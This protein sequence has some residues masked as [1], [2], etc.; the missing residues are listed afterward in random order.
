MSYER[1]SI[2]RLEAYVPGEQPADIDGVIK[3]NTNEN[4][5]PPA[6]AVMQT[7]QDLPPEALRRYPPPDAGSFRAAAAA[8]HGVRCNQV[9]ATNGGDEL[10]RLAVTVF[11]EP[12]GDG[13]H[14]GIGVTEPSYS[15]YSVLGAIANTPVTSICRTSDFDLPPD[16]ANR[17]NAEGCRL[18][19]IVN[20]HAPSGALTPLATLHSLA[21]AF[22]GVLLVDEAYVDFASA[23]ALSLVRPDGEALDNVLLLRSLSKGYS[24]AGLRFGYGIGAAPL[25]AALD[26]ARD[27]YNTDV[28]SQV[29][30]VA[31]IQ[32]PDVA[33]AG[34]QR[35]QVQRKRLGDELGDR[36]YR[37][38]PSQ[39]NFLLVEPPTGGST[40]RQLYEALRAKRILVRHFDS[41]RLR[42]TLRITIGTDR[43][44]DSLLAVLDE[45]AGKY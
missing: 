36:G 1:P 43:Q 23:D 39:A 10:L 8:V 41:D 15:L 40:A 14:G 3:L 31:A 19:F 21:E 13:G 26:K 44:H 45:V 7:I 6:S 28:L 18:G 9:I 32:Q 20:P 30:A 37:V 24:L 4:P 17:W 22:N 25:I 33:R 12:T 42:D 29:V 34:W 11:C 35:I 27:S 5:Y 38:Y 16:L 2:Q